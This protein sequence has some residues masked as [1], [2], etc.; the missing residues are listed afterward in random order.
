MNTYF[1]HQDSVEDTAKRLRLFLNENKGRHIIFSHYFDFSVKKIDRA[2][3]GNIYNLDSNT[4]NKVDSLT[5]SFSSTE[6]KTFPNNW[7]YIQINY[8]QKFMIRPGELFIFENLYKTAYLFFTDGPNTLE[9]KCS[10]E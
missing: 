8:N 4:S 9:F 3:F 1:L 6:V 10:K 5:T 7:L 2:K